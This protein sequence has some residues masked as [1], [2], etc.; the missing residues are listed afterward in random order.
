MQQ[1]TSGSAAAPAY[2]SGDIGADDLKADN[3]RDQYFYRD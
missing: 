3:R 1:Q 2:A